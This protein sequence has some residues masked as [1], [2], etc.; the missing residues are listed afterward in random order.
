[1]RGSFATL[2]HDRAS[3]PSSC[4]YHRH[5]HRH[6][7]CFT[8]MLGKNG[9]QPLK[10]SPSSSS[11]SSTCF[12]LQHH[13]GQAGSPGPQVWAYTALEPWSSS[14][15]LCYPWGAW[16]IRSCWKGV[17]TRHSCGCVVLP[18]IGHTRKSPLSHS[19]GWDHMQSSHPHPSQSDL[20]H[21]LLAWGALSNHEQRDGRSADCCWHLPGQL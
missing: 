3:R 21:R 2:V 16:T 18:Q 4:C 5:H 11:S 6:A 14:T 15:T 9:P 10:L 7:S 1:M 13:V 17:A 20:S 8:I 12:L 19:G